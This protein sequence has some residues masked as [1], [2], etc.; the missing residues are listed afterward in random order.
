[1][2]LS[3]AIVF[4]H[5]ILGDINIIL[6]TD[7][8][9]SEL[10]QKYLSHD[11]FTDIITFDFSENN[12]L[13]GEIYISIDRIKENA[14]IFGNTVFNELHRIMIHG[15]LHLCGYNDK[16]KKEK[17]QMILKEDHYLSIRPEIL[18]I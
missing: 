6:C 18:R 10:N 14:S 5:K 2:W 16:S 17:E 12:I 8:F 3:D 11:T 15:V 9:L 1:M 4:E 7:S 13:S